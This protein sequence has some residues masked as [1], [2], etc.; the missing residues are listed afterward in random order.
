[1]RMGK[2]ATTR[3]LAS[4]NMDVHKQFVAS[5][6]AK[7]GKAP[8]AAAAWLHAVPMVSWSMMPPSLSH[9]EVALAM[10]VRFSASFL[11]NDGGLVSCKR[12]CLGWNGI[13]R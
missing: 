3:T 8:T 11:F 13:V 5:L 12:K 9:C 2:V 1:M 6:R 10:P 7:R 4:N